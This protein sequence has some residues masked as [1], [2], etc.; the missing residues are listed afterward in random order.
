MPRLLFEALRY[1]RQILS[2]VYLGE[3]WPDRLPGRGVLRNCLLARLLLRKKST[4]D[5]LKPARLE[6]ICER[7]AS[8][9]LHCLGSS[10][11]SNNQASARYLHIPYLP[12][13]PSLLFLLLPSV[14][15]IRSVYAKNRLV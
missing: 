3:L 12:A 5:S 4:K 9:A 15:A 6:G 7:R 11:E 1:D 14:R 13:A 8:S 2:R 10:D